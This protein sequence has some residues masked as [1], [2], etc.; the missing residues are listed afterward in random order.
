MIKNLLRSLEKQ[1]SITVIKRVLQIFVQRF[2]LLIRSFCSASSRKL[3][4]EIQELFR[5]LLSIIQQTSASCSE[6]T[7]N[8]FRGLLSHI[9]R[10][11]RAMKYNLRHSSE[12][13]IVLRKEYSSLPVVFSVKTRRLLDQ[14][15]KI[16]GVIFLLGV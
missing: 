11:L 14:V 3:L 5:E 4:I 8:K 13:F 16:S 10:I 2:S 7:W 15:M 12:N 6:N 1:T 9:R